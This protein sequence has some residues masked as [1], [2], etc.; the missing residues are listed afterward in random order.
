MIQ[1]EKLTKCYR[2]ENQDLCVLRDLDFSVPQGNVLALMGPSGAGKTTVLNIIAGLDNVF[3]GEV[4]VAGQSLRK[5]NNKQLNSYRN[6]TIGYIFQEF[7]LLPHLN[8]LENV[9]T[10]MMFSD[11]SHAEAEVK[12]LTMLETV[13]LK[14]FSDQMPS[15]LS[16][17]Q[18]QRVAVARALVNDPGVILADEPT[19]NLDSNSA[20]SVLDL[21]VRLTKEKNATLILSTHREH[22]AALATDIIELK[23]QEWQEHEGGDR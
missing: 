18:K 3:S 1:V 11:I 21:I 15:Q 20:K 16:G 23:D 4:T 10:P 9:L 19:A 12:A 17:G 14:E 6:T 13:G 8:A 2:K 5:L 22:L 7:F